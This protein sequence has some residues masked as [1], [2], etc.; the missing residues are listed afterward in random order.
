MENK[1]LKIG[2][3]IDE[4]IVDFMEN[5]L[6]FHNEKYNTNLTKEDFNSYNFWEIWGGT[7]EEAI[8]KFDNFYN[9]YFFEKISPIPEAKEAI[10]FLSDSHEL[11]IITARPIRIKEKTQDFFRKHFLDTNLNIIFTGDF[12][13]EQGKSKSDICGDLGVDYFIEDNKSY[14]FECANKGVKVFL[15]DKPWNQNCE[16][17]NI[18][19]V[20]N[21]KEIMEKI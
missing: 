7:K 18:V 11:F 20:K 12:F 6:L 1:K 3:D 19:R 15:I 5:I 17:E 2:I 8:E 21:W 4:V 10:N 9:S 13:K 14:A 16:H